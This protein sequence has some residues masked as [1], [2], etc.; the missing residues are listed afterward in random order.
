MIAQVD[1][2]DH[3]WLASTHGVHVSILVYRSDEHVSG[4]MEY[5]K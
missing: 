4:A 3:R 1:V 5:A 2:R